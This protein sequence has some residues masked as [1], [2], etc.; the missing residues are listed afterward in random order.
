MCDILILQ[1][2]N[3]EMNISEILTII[4]VFLNKSIIVFI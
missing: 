1:Y 2:K 3:K 4:L